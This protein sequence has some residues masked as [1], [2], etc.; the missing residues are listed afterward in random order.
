MNS[1]ELKSIG[2]NDSLTHVDFMVGCS[3]MDIDGELPD[4]TTVPIFRSGN[5]AF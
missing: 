3:D 4:G 1:D 2:L 5:W